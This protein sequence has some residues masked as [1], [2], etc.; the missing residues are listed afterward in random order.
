MASSPDSILIGIELQNAGENLN[1]WGDPQLNT[2]LQVVARSAHGYQSLSLADSTTISGTNYVAT[3]FDE[4]ASLNIGGTPSAA[5]NVVFPARQKR[6][7]VKNS[8]SQTATLKLAASTGFALPAGRTAWAVITGS[9]VE[10]WSANYIAPITG[11]SGQTLVDVDYLNQAI[12]NISSGFSTNGT[13]FVTSADTTANYLASKLEAGSGIT[14]TTTS[15]ASNET[16]RITNS[17][18]ILDTI[19]LAD[20]SVKSADFDVSANTRYILDCTSTAITAY[21][22]SAPTVGDQIL[23]QKFGNTKGFDFNPSGKNVLGNTGNGTLSADYEGPRLLVYTGSAR[24]W[25]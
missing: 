20:G 8:T 2:A 7:L 17:R 9:D 4:V 11:E 21:G 25:C 19:I 12:A 6:L 1:T 15:V 10:N 3:N 18:P 16:I 5:F 13:V 24:G 14:L 23:F 22:S